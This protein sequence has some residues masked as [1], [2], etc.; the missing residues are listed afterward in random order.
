MDLAATGLIRSS[1]TVLT[2]TLIT[3]YDHYVA[4]KKKKKKKK[5]KMNGKVKKKKK[6]KK[7][8]SF[9]LDIARE[10][11]T[12]GRRHVRTERDFRSDHFLSKK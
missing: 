10:S 5:K 7:K 8:K 6:K 9:D 1:R 4:K 3:C 11:S 2:T 12:I